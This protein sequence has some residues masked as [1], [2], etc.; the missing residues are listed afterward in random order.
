L[1]RIREIGEPYKEEI[2]VDI[3][4]KVPDDEITIYHIGE[5]DDPSHWWD[6]CA[7]PHVGTTGDINNDAFK[8]EN[9]A[10][11]YWR[12]DE[13]NQQLTRI[14]GTAWK[15]QT[16]LKA[17]EVLKKEAASRDHR[18]LGAELKLFRYHQSLE[19]I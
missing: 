16:E 4:R 12:G 13:N 18:K 8:L 5:K 11:A 14:Y 3:L 9:I 19:Y 2:L 6:L 7:G 15:T 17:Y 10:G 1:R